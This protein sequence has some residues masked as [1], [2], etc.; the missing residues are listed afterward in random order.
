MAE[1]EEKY[2]GKLLRLFREVMLL[3]NSPLGL[4]I[5]EL[6]EKLGVSYRTVYRDLDVLRNS[7]F[8][9]EE[10]SRGKFMIRGLD[11]EVEKLKDNLRFS[12]EEAGI[13]SQA[14]SS[15]PASNPMREKV[16]E[17]LLAFSGMEDALKI[18]VKADVSRSVE[19]L[20]RAVKNREVVVLHNYRSS[21]SQTIRDREVEPYAF[22]NDGQF[23]KC[24]EDASVANKSFKIER[25]GEVI[26]TG[27]SWE[28]ESRHETVREADIFG[29]TGSKTFQISL[30]I[31]IRAA[32]L[33][34]E[35]FP[36]SRP[37]IIKENADQFRF[38][39]PVHSLKGISRFILGL[40]DEIEVEGPAELVSF[41]QEKIAQK[42]F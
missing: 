14:V 39:A 33:L 20:S 23:V 18:A 34:Q 10:I 38:E 21:N 22:S 2:K 11:R 1:N 3:Y 42:S 17:K 32:N 4:S 6:A 7:G 31:S 25:I 27:K 28:N 41:L 24:Y 15:I 12:A 8:F 26:L 40:I 16:L 5:N 13:L 9:P 36:L 30:L 35:E 37:Y 19:L 29:F